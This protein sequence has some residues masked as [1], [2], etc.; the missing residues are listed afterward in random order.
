M[1]LLTL[2]STNHGVPK[3]KEKN[4]WCYCRNTELQGGRFWS[5][6]TIT[7]VW[8]LHGCISCLT[9]LVNSVSKRF[10]LRSASPIA[11][12]LQFK[13][14]PDWR[15][16]S[17]SSCTAPHDGH[18]DD[19]SPS[20]A[21]WETGCRKLTTG[22]ESKSTWRLWRETSSRWRQG[23]RSREIKTDICGSD[24]EGFQ[25]TEPSAGANRTALEDPA[26]AKS[27]YWSDAISNAEGK[28]SN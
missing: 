12:S 25:L 14:H 4:E 9:W 16:T 19:S 7:T 27:L 11:S 13:N 23:S 1:A 5:E 10:T 8:Y 15:S 20:S 24:V 21:Q 22:L 28:N 3:M 2:I 17:R 6:V 26:F 18:D